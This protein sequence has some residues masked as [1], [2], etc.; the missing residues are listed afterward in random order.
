L[1]EEALIAAEWSWNKLLFALWMHDLVE[2]ERRL[3]ALLVG[4]G[5]LWLFLLGH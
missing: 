2:A 4:A 1:R 5:T 3:K